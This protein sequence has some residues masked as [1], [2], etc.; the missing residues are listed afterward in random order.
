VTQ[1]V[2][3][4][5]TGDDWSVFILPLFGLAFVGGVALL[6]SAMKNGSK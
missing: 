1:L 4:G 2:T 3:F 6:K 5:F